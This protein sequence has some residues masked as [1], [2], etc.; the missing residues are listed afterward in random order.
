MCKAWKGGWDGIERCTSLSEE[1]G[2]AED[3]GGKP[4]DNKRP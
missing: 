3:I 2:V 1:F 4:A